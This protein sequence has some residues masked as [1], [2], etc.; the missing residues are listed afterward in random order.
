M[1]SSTCLVLPGHRGD[2]HHPGAALWERYRE[3]IPVVVLD[4]RVTLCARPYGT[5]MGKGD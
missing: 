5:W 2:G 1:T 4:E 3:V